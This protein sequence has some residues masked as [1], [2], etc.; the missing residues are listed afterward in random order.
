MMNAGGLRRLTQEDGGA[1]VDKK[2]AFG[3]H[4]AL[5]HLETAARSCWSESGDGG[6]VRLCFWCA[7]PVAVKGFVVDVWTAGS[8]AAALGA[9]PDGRVS[10][11]HVRT[12]V[13]QHFCSLLITPA[14]TAW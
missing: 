13:F 1:D 11:Q 14:H 9:I 3:C 2:K 8:V 5:L 4:D 6:A 10:W 7:C 12:G